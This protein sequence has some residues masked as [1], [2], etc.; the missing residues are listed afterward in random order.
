MR[1]ERWADAVFHGRIHHQ[2]HRHHPA[3]RRAALGVFEVAGGRQKAR[4]VEQANA[5]RGM[6]L[7]FVP[8]PKRLGR[9][10]GGVE[11]LGRTD[12]TPVLVDAG[13]TDSS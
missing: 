12:T 8:V 4:V 3:P 5:A 7:A 1:F 13:L 10:L 2:A 6:A 11:G 9:P